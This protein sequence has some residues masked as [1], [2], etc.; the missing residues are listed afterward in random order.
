MAKKKSGFG[1][2]TIIAFA[3]VVVGLV[4][5]IVGYTADWMKTTVDSIAGS[6][7]SASKL[8]DLAEAYDTLGDTAAD[9]M[10][11]FGVM[12]AFAIITFIAM[13]V[14][15]CGYVVSAIIRLR[16]LKLVTA[17]AGVVTVVC[18]VIVLITSITFAGNYGGIDIGI[19][20]T[21]YTIAVGPILMLGRRRAGRRGYGRRRH[22]KVNR[23]IHDREKPEAYASGFSFSS[24]PLSLAFATVGPQALRARRPHRSPPTGKPAQYR[25]ISAFTFAGT[26]TVSSMP[27]GTRAVYTAVSPDTFQLTAISPRTLSYRPSACVSRPEKSISG[28]NVS[29]ANPAP[30]NDGRMPRQYLNIHSPQLPY[31]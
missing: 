25:S 26:S 22:E 16:I 3:V 12:N 18:A 28:F 24:L 21:E 30:S 13:I 20:S 9:I 29:F 31:A 1:L 7:S 8:S 27:S 23:T 5:V 2:M 11:G 14:S 19:V 17:L 10:K 4:L 6:T 15:A